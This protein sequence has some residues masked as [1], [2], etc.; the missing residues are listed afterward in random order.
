MGI[1]SES[2]YGTTTG[3]SNTAIGANALQANTTGGNNVAIG[4]Q[5]GNSVSG[6]NSNNIEIGTLGSSGDSGTIRI[7]T[8]GTQTSSYIAGVYGVTLP[9]SGQPLVCIST[10][11]QLG[12]SNCATNG[13]P[14][15]QQEI[16][17]RQ[18]QQIQML[19]KQNEEFQQRLARLESLVANR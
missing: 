3:S 10:A 12:T 4:Y 11:G 15:T 13:A 8:S 1:G 9:T 16:I 18:Q 14:G 5:A 2:L 7:G 19:Q 17:N 6:G